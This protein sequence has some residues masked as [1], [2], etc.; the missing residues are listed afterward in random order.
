MRFAAL[1]NDD[2][3]FC[4]SIVELNQA[5][6]FRPKKAEAFFAHGELRKIA[7]V[8]KEFAFCKTAA[9]VRA[10]SARFRP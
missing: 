6:R 8:S 3:F 9:E 4:L 7:R 5:H 10:G 1:K 2:S